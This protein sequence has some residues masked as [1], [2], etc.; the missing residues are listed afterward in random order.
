MD[1]WLTFGSTSQKSFMP[2]QLDL[3]FTALKF[4]KGKQGIFVLIY[5]HDVKLP[6]NVWSHRL[7]LLWTLVREVSEWSEW[8]NDESKWFFSGYP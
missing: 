5:G 6:S 4:L 1:F 7:L 3:K 8:G 2:G